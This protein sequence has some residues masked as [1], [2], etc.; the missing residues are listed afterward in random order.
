MHIPNLLQPFMIKRRSNVTNGGEFV[1][2][3]PVSVKRPSE[4]RFSDGL[5][6]HKKDG[7]RGA[8]RLKNI[9]VR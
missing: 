8:G 1:V 3:P 2:F 5:C 7:L 9:R 4:S 6:L